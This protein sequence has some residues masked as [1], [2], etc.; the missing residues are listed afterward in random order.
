MRGLIG[1]NLD[2]LAWTQLWSGVDTFDIELSPDAKGDLRLIRLA[3]GAALPEHGHQGEELTLVL[4]GAF[5]DA[6]GSFSAGDFAD[7]DDSH[8]HVVAAAEDGECI[9][10]VASETEPAFLT[11]S[12]S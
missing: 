8:R 12:P 2:E 7:L 6:F 4:R 10:L 11:G 1:R 9:I 5:N 3:P